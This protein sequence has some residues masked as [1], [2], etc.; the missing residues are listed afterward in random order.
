M[1]LSGPE[2]SVRVHE[3][4]L[5]PQKT[6]KPP[7]EERKKH[8]RLSRFLIGSEENEEAEGS[9]HKANHGVGKR[10][11]ENRLCYL[12]STVEVANLG[13]RWRFIFFS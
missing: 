6:K 7:S 12:Q 4:R 5:T 9:V 10:L 1:P 13:V 8:I 3:E 11:F 2:A